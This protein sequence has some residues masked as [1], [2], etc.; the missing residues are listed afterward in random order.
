[1]IQRIRRLPDAGRA[2]R[3]HAAFAGLFGGT[4]R[5]LSALHVPS[6]ELK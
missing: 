3:V 5:H 6:D 2:T 1:M 4:C